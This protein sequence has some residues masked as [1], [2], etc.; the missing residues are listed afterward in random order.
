M[1][2]ERQPRWEGL[3]EVGLFT[4]RVPEADGGVGLG[5]P[6]AV[7][8]FE[9]VGR[10]LL[11]G[12][13]VGTEL[14]ETLGLGGRA[15]VIRVPARGPV[16]VPHFPTLDHVLLLDADDRL[17]VLAVS[18]LPG[19]TELSGPVE[20]AGS[21]GRPAR[22]VD[23]RTPLWGLTSPLPEGEPG[24][25]GARVA[26]ESSLLVAALQVGLAAGT[27]TEAVH[28]ACR[29]EQFGRS[30]GAFQAV[31]HLC[32]DMLARTELARVAVYAAAVSGDP[33]DIAGA[34]LLADAAAV[35]GAR[36]CLQVH[37]GMGFTWETPV[38]LLP[39]RAW[40]WEQAGADRERCLE[41]LAGHL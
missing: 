1:L 21:R 23:P 4:L 11:P 5:L 10:A 9:E 16:L 7:L 22:A 35:H 18:E 29:R 30:I 15:E 8:A 41:F 12:P 28:H 40:A 37:G 20:P 27:V 6:E 39:K 36:G 33:E 13:L 32:A 14:A 19:P 38:H 34:K 25:E 2:M 17:V 24:L 31:R 26:T 3:V